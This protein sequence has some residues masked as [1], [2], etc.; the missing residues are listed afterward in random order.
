VPEAAEVEVV[1]RQLVDLLPGKTIDRVWTDGVS[2]RIAHRDVPAAAGATVTS[3]SRHGKYLTIHLAG[4][5]HDRLHLHL[6]MTGTLRT[7]LDR[8]RHVRAR[9]VLSGE[10]QLV[11][12]DPRRFGQLTVQTPATLLRAGPDVCDPTLAPGQLVAAATSMAGS[13]A[14]AVT[15]QRLVAGPGRY[16]TTEALWRARIHPDI[17]VAA[18]DLERWCALLP[19]LRAVIRAAVAVGGNTFSDFVDVSGRPGRYQHQLVVYGRAGQ[20]CQRCRTQLVTTDA[21]RVVHCPQCQPQ[22]G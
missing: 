3:I 12:N 16:V 5:R 17:P 8:C 22:C 9:L 10:L 14:T 4:S 6:G 13:V 19:A 15:S 11:Y 20:P 7:D 18:L 2:R 1:H 21:S